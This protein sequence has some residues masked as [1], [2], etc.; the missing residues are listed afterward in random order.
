M[1]PQNLHIASPRE[2]LYSIKKPWDL[3]SSA[4]NI[5]HCCYIWSCVNVS[6]K[7]TYSHSK[8]ISFTS[9]LV[10]VLYARCFC[11]RAFFY[12]LWNHGK[13]TFPMNPEHEENKVQKCTNVFRSFPMCLFIL[14]TSFYL[15]YGDVLPLWAIFQANLDWNRDIL[16]MAAVCYRIIMFY[17]QG[18][19]SKG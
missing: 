3:L 5:L 10:D 15:Q 2:D 12:M 9:R 1:F 14:G 19:L 11:G 7:S 17:A 8:S 6:S 4:F 16:S 18:L 13:L